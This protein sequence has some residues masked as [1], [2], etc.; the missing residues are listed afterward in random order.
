MLLRILY[1]NKKTLP[2][3]I[4]GLEIINSGT[5]PQANFVFTK[6]PEISLFKRAYGSYFQIFSLEDM[7]TYKQALPCF[8]DLDAE[9]KT[10][11]EKRVGQ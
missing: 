10:L 8:K 5:F 7:E 6:N 2:N 9:F 1:E 11:L 3:K 4:L